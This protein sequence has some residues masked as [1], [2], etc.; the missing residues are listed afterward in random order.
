MSLW[1]RRALEVVFKVRLSGFEHI[2]CCRVAHKMHRR[3]IL[4]TKGDSVMIEVPPDLSH[5]RIT[6]WAKQPGAQMMS[7]IADMTLFVAV[8]GSATAALASLIFVSM[9]F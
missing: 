2:V 8:I 6:V 9:G 4:L 1:R 5:G 3:H 7:T